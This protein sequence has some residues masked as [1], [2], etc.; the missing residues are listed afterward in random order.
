MNR[1]SPAVAAPPNQFYTSST[2][3]RAS[4]LEAEKAVGSSEQNSRQL[5]S[6]LSEMHTQINKL[7]AIKKMKS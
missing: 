7:K 3:V 6:Y 4:D 5:E 2:D 1:A